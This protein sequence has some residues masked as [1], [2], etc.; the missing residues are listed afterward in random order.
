MQLFMRQ[1]FFSIMVTNSVSVDTH[2]HCVR[3]NLVESLGQPSRLK[4][5]N[6]LWLYLT[7]WI[8]VVYVLLSE[9]D[10][11]KAKKAER[12]KNTSLV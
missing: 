8:H 9:C 6:I 10:Q 4:H 3:C 12:E 11:D 7:K 1:H 2:A 5:L